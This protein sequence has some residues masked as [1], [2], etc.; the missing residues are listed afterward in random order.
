MKLTVLQ[1]VVVKDNPFRVPGSETIKTP[2][3]T[4]TLTDVYNN[5]IH[6]ENATR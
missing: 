4:I 5:I 6:I 2:V 3:F 1:N